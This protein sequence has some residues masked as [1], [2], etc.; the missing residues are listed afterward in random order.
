MKSRYFNYCKKYIML[1]L[2]PLG[3]TSC[4][5]TGNSNTFLR[6][7]ISNY[8]GMIG[9]DIPNDFKLENESNYSKIIEM[10]DMNINN[11]YVTF[12]TIDRIIEVCNVTFFCADFSAAREY[13][14]YLLKYLENDHWEYIE[15]ISKYKQSYG[16]LYHKNDIYLG[17]YEP[18]SMSISICFSINKSLNG[19]YEQNNIDQP[20]MIYSIEYYKNK[21]I[22]YRNFF[23]QRQKISAIIQINDIIPDYLC[24]LVCWD[25]NL[26]GNI[27]ELYSF[28]K[29]HII[30]NKYLVG[31]GPFLK[32]YIEKLMEK[33]PGNKINRELVSFGDFNND[34][35]NE[36]LSYSLYPNIGYVFTVFGYSEIEM[37]FTQVCLVPVFIN[38]EKP[39]PPVEYIGNGFLILEIVDN[40]NL[41]LAWNKY[42]WDEK[43]QKYIKRN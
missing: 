40:N 5:N 9:K 16:G 6:E 14:Q 36:I 2:F 8:S 23:D 37:D 28:N 31:Y 21:V 32:N 41:D 30:V 1:L 4:H 3:F 42:L 18:V 20:E 39:F 27:H 34:G 38:F 7:F 33:I 43:F 25:D 24:F 15:Y 35:K 11:V 22:E 17:L 13:Y 10:N 29:N 12:K 26:K 19:F